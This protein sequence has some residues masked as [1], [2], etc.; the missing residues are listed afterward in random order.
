M[1]SAGDNYN[2]LRDKT[3]SD[4]GHQWTTYTE[5]DGFYGS[6]ELLED[7]LYPFIIKSE[8][9]GSTDQSVAL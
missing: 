8:I 3:I 4:F 5:N 1:K 7:I 2:E 9:I 6:V